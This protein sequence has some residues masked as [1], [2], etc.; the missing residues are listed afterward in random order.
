MAK[1]ILILGMH[2]S[3]T[4]ALTEL[5]HHLGI[6]CG[7]EFYETKANWENLQGFWERE[8][9]RQLNN[10]LLKAAGANWSHLTDFDLT[11]ISQEP[12]DNFYEKARL[13]ITELNK[14]SSWIIKDP[15]LCIVLPLWK[16]LLDRPICIIIWRDPLAVAKSLQTRNK[17]FISQGIALWEYYNLAALNN[18]V[19]FARLLISHADLLSAP[20]K[21]TQEI[22]QFLHEQGIAGLDNQDIEKL[23]QVIDP[24]LQH[25]K[26]SKPSIM[27][28]ILNGQQASLWHA[29]KNKSALNVELPLNVSYGGHLG[30]KELE[31]LKGLEK[32]LE[33][34]SG[35]LEKM[36]SH[37]SSLLDSLQYNFSQ[38][39]FTT[40]R[41]L[42]GKKRESLTLSSER[43]LREVLSC[44]ISLKIKQ[45]KEKRA[46]VELSAPV[47]LP[48]RQQ[49][50][51]QVKNDDMNTDDIT[52]DIVICVHN[53]L[54]DVQAAL[55]SI[56]LNRS[57]FFRLIIVNDGSD[58][59]TSA[60]LHTFVEGKDWCTLHENST[61]CGYTAAANQGMLSTTAQFVVIV[62]SDVV[63][64][65]EWLQVLKRCAYSSDQ[66]GMVGPLS[67]AA[68]WQ[69]IP[70]RKDESGKWSINTIPSGWTVDKMQSLIA[71]ISERRYPRV[72]LLNGF[73]LGVKRAVFEKIGYLDEKA[74]SQGYGEENDFCIRAIKAG[75]ELAITDDL[76][77][78]HA[79]S[80]SFGSVRRE[81]L[82]K[83]ANSVLKRRYGRTFGTKYTKELRE[84][85]ALVRMRRR[86]TTAFL[87]DISF[88]QPKE[89]TPINIL[90]LLPCMPGSG[91][92]NS[93][94]QEVQELNRMNFL[95]T[96]AVPV[97]YRSKYKKYYNKEALQS[98]YFYATN[99]ELFLLT[100]DYD[101]VVATY[102]ASVSLLKCLWEKEKD[103]LPAYYIQDYEP[104]FFC[105][106]FAT[107][108]QASRSYT[109]I[110]NLC[111]FAKTD[112]ICDIV[113]KKHKVTVHRIMPSI[114]H[115][116]FY[117]DPNDLG[118][119]P[120]PPIHITA[121]IRPRTPRR[122]ASET[123]E[124]LKEI[125]VEYGVQV[126]IHFFGT[127]STDPDFI[128]L[129][130]DF[131]FI[132]HG[133]LT[134]E[135]VSNL[136]RNSDIFLDMSKWQAFGRTGIEAMAC[137][138]VPVLPIRGGVYEYAVN[139]YNAM[140]VDTDEKTK[141]IAS[142]QELINT[143][144]LL[145]VLK[146]N[147]LRDVKR[148]SIALASRS[149]ALLFME[150]INF[151]EIQH[152]CRTKP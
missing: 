151:S 23:S 130:R 77:I 145:Q 122:R 110:P 85:A 120:T 68:T 106:D 60:F 50:F 108:W 52:T 94:M 36:V 83:Q 69:S 31:G 2:R 71:D 11:T 62:N 150:Q 142:I 18:S 22:V 30:I 100:P 124:V 12:L 117:S 47:L 105:S 90:F 136:L 113:R 57:H 9:V 20:Q 84:N 101:V 70:N 133:F 16:K 89:E 91:G 19:G 74:F 96:V 59:P 37:T 82:S 139:R 73:C 48:E 148:Y 95:T 32:Q 140:I 132:N 138:C 26:S 29:L 102:F 3:G 147:G 34:T 104:W 75:F 114:D 115:N 86:I 54:E 27:Q 125:Q 55:M 121:M 107:K 44:F 45:L 7:N 119:L 38:L 15:R 35:M 92:V 21:T 63:V 98:V 78:Y 126:S 152:I 39:V 141:V 135:S 99:E 1:Q 5:V 28:S 14:H 49:P 97:S 24:T 149:L 8:D 81:E 143:P 41:R 64:P 88:N 33:T 131:D 109:K 43:N 13:L 42:I 76:F 25:Y 129:N 103:F 144:N 56:A 46:H 137:G 66:I 4:S 112:W 79:K 80:K 58:Q 17:F 128:K 87:C 116:V 53:A 65:K 123:L 127:D 10:F 61:P 67:N 93:V 40:Y 111:C 146:E 118:N 6:Y 72:Q 134:R 51:I